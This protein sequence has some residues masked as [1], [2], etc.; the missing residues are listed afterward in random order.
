MGSLAKRSFINNHAAQPFSLLSRIA[1]RIYHSAP[2]N[3]LDRV[4][5]TSPIP[6]GLTRHDHCAG[7]RYWEVLQTLQ[8]QN[9][10]NNTLIFSSDNGSPGARRNLPSGQIRCVRG[11]IHVP[12]VASGRGMP[13][14]TVYDQPVS[15]WILSHDCSVAGVSLPQT[16]CMTA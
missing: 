5:P 10:L 11:G 13:A 16:D 14:N 7:R 1:L 3:Y 6:N 9:L 15:L 2:Q 4:S 12:F 8:T